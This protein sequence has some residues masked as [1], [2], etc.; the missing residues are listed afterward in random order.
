MQTTEKK[1]RPGKARTPQWVILV[2]GAGDADALRQACEPLS[3][4]SLAAAGAALPV[5]HGLYQLQYNPT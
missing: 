2:E 5:E 3:E 1:T 4:A